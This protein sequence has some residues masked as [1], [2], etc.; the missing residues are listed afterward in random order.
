M[1]IYDLLPPIPERLCNPWFKI[2]YVK[3]NQFETELSEPL[4]LI[5]FGLRCLKRKRPRSNNNKQRSARL[6]LHYL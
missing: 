4:G 1:E 3:N 2:D 6:L 5:G